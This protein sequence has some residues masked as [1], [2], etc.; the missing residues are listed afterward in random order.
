VDAVTVEEFRAVLLAA[1]SHTDVV[2]PPALRGPINH[3]LRATEERVRRENWQTLL[4]RPV[5]P[6]QEAAQAIL[7]AE[8]VELAAVC[9][10]RHSDG[11]P[12]W[13]RAHDSRV[14]L[15]SEMRWFTLPDAKWE[16][17][18]L[19]GDELRDAPDALKDRS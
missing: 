11:S 19:R 2:Q 14:H 6:E 1:A 5:V 16:N 3:W 4:S 18:D 12:C 15:T 13:L 8:S 10:A 7:A 9:P 17:A